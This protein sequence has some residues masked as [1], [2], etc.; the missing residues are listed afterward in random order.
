MW[1]SGKEFACQ[2]KRL[3]LD[4]SWED[5]LEKEAAT[6]SSILAGEIPWI[7]KLG[8]LHTVHGVAVGHN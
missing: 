2:C 8:G 6:H 5:S 1:L 3:E 4:P 7:E